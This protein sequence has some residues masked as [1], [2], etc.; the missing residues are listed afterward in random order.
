MRRH[1][2]VDKSEEMVGRKMN[3]QERGK[4][5]EEKLWREDKA[6]NEDWREKLERVWKAQPGLDHSSDGPRSGAA[7]GKMWLWT[8]ARSGSR[9]LRTPY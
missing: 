2:P 6:G 7:S 3:Q 5:L 9:Q 4:R 8:R 1:A